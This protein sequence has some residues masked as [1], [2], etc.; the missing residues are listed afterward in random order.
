M[1]FLLGRGYVLGPLR[2]L[3]TYLPGPLWFL[4]TYSPGPLRFIRTYLLG[5]LRLLRT[6]LPGP[7]QLLRQGSFSKEQLICSVLEGNH[8]GFGSINILNFRLFTLVHYMI[9][10]MNT[11]AVFIVA[12]VLLELKMIP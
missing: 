8:C 3:R 5:P 12:L 9:L 1:A 10:S 11:Y 7:L 2:L 6:Y 4:R